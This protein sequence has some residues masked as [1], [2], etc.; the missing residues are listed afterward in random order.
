MRLVLA[1]FLLCCAAVVAA[2][3]VLGQSSDRLAERTG[4]G[5]IWAGAALLALATSLPELVTGVAAVRMHATNLA[6]GDLFGSSLANMLILGA[7]ALLATKPREAGAG[8]NGSLELTVWMAVTLNLMGACFVHFHSNRSWFGVHPESTLLLIGYL[9][10]I[11]WICHHPDSG[12]P[13]QAETAA[14][15]TLWPDRSSWHA[16]AQFAAGAA[17]IFVAAPSLAGQAARLAA[18][19]GLGD[20]FVGTF[21]VGLT[22]ALPEFV[23][24]ATAVRLG[25]FDLAVATLYGSCACNMAIFFF[26]DLASGSASIFDSVAPVQA[27]TGLLAAALM[28]GWWL[29]ARRRQA[30]RRAILSPSSALLALAYGF[31]IWLVHIFT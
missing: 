27:L 5:Q 29:A 8:A 2:G 26:L 25:A 11:R 3:I 24:S 7:V 12:S 31:A 23:T 17:V 14:G 20:S 30:R 28:L 4:L 13:A 1:N 10:G 21:M 9:G 6:A 15:R 19:S 22:T 18:V 16:L